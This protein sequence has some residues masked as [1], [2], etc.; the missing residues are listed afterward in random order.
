M[1]RVPMDDLVRFG[2]CFMTKRG[3]PEDRAEYLAAVVVEAEAFRQS[4]HGL[5]Q[6]KHIH[7]AL[8]KDI[9][10]EAEPVVARDRGAT[11]LVDGNRS[12]G[13]LAMKVA[14]E[15]A[16][17]KAREHG[18]GFV[19]VRNSEWVG[20][21]G[22]HLISIAEEGLLAKAWAQT[23]GCK[24]CA[25]IGGIDARFSTNPIALAFPAPG[26][27]VLADFS[28]AAMSLGTAM[29][30]K[31]QGRKTAFPRFLDKAGQPSDDPAVVSQ[32]GTLMFA[33]GDAEGHKCYGLSLFNEALTVLAGGSAN[34]PDLTPHQSFALLVL[35][36]AG[37][38]GG[39]YFADEMARYVTFLKSSRIRPGFEELRLPGDRGFAALA[40]SRARGV[41][42][43]EGKLEMLRGIAEA[44]GVDP[45][46]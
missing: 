44:N 1:K 6:Y 4:T 33:G 23:S 7:E 11:A 8:G 45:P 42:L 3:V 22:T 16:V 43:D 21:L 40:D 24:D 12:F 19:A 18:I 9:D 2:K 25:P 36:P 35:D 37:F 26:H 39:D 17:N 31:Q 41:P 32:G 14:K 38:A 15:L 30:L 20:A 46:G 13:N 5:A 29:A 34:N 28:T 10:P 27:P